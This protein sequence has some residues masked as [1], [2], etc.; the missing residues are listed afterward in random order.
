VVLL[1]LL[2]RRLGVV[3]PAAEANTARQRGGEHTHGFMR[4]VT[5]K[6]RT[7]I[8]WQLVHRKYLAGVCKACRGLRRDETRS[9]QVTRSTNDTCRGNYT[10]FEVQMYS[11][12]GSA[13]VV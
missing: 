1:V 5:H 7:E 8:S 9:Q 10:Y 13:G 6:G 12:G 11:G 3:A 2:R 4:H